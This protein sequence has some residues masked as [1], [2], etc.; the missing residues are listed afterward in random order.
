LPRAWPGVWRSPCPFGGL[1]PWASLKVLV[2]L[3]NLWT[4]VTAIVTAIVTISS[5]SIMCGKLLDGFPNR[6][7]YGHQRDISRSLGT[8]ALVVLSQL[9]EQSP[10][11]MVSLGQEGDVTWHHGW[12]QHGAP[13]VARGQDSSK[14]GIGWDG[15]ADGV[16]Y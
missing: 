7:L 1:G 15:L 9:R 4:I 13:P 14:L 16:A 10:S 12:I 5:I 11:E 8:S 6:T 2:V 3:E